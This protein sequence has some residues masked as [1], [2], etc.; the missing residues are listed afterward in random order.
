MFAAMRGLE[1]DRIPLMCQLSPGHILKN[2]GIEPLDYWFTPEGLAEGYIRM[3]E[4]Y[5]F[6]GILICK[7]D[8]I[9]PDLVR[10]FVRQKD[11][12]NGK[13]I[14]FMNGQNYLCPPDD[15]PHLLDDTPPQIKSVEEVNPE[16]IKVISSAEEG[17][18]WFGNILDIVL[19][20]KQ[21]ELSI[22]GEIGTS[23]ES[24]L[25]QF[26]SFEGGLLAL[27]DNPAKCKEIIARINHNCLVYARAQC[28]RGIDALKLS[29][30]LAGAGFI[31][32]G[33]YEEFVLPYEKAIVDMAHD[34]FGVPCYT[35]T[36]GAIGDRLELMLASGID[37][38]ECLD[39][40]PLGTVDLAAAV[41]RI[42]NRCFIKGNLDSVNELTKTPNEVF[43]IA[44]ERIAVGRKAK[45]YILSS[46]CSVSPKVPPENILILSK[47]VRET[48]LT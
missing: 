20:R 7:W 13:L 24:A 8:G 34:E 5:N 29:S 23:F 12:P 11:T 2:S 28:A 43:K 44:M 47:A 10:G 32:S 14:E 9:D 31:S 19:E 6:D 26:G 42:G 39:P 41:D 3:A 35:H 25:R 17:I 46:A 30:P 18:P 36:C 48:V 4:K 38:L 37:G 45:G 1:V 16:N 21:G 40:P 15:N 27:I 33:M 22:H